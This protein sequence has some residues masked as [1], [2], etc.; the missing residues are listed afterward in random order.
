MEASLRNAEH[1]SAG[2]LTTDEEGSGGRGSEIDVF[3]NMT[4]KVKTSVRSSL[5]KR[6]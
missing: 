2:S 3:T 6:R 1:R 5:R 4:L